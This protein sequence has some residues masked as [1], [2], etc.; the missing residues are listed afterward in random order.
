MPR[1]LRRPSP[2]A[3]WCAIPEIQPRLLAVVPARGGSRG[4]PGKNIR[5]FAGLPLI[6]HSI[7]LARMCVGIDRCVVSTDS[8]EIR[9]VALDYGADV[10]F[11]RPGNLAHDDTPLWPV[12]QHALSSVEEIEGRSYDYILLLDPTSPARLPNDISTAFQTLAGNPEADGIIGVS[13][14]WFNPI[15]HCVTERD[16]WMTDLFPEAHSLNRRQDAPPVYR[17]NGSLYIWRATFL[18]QHTEWRK[19]KLLM[20]EIPELRAMSIDDL[21]EFERAEVLVKAGLIELPWL[22]QNNAHVR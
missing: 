22:E 13:M 18:M 15:W 3:R 19:G 14:P 16:G 17:I 4:L 11:E 1:V 7:L 10:P 20:H 5:P 12:L 8:P 9:K 21:A 6:A 2:G